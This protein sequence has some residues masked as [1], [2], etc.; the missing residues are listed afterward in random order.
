MTLEMMSSRMNPSEIQDFGDHEIVGGVIDSEVEKL[1]LKEKE[2]YGE[3][4]QYYEVLK[5][6]YGRFYFK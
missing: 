6:D 3:L 5:Q 2:K 4:K 1:I